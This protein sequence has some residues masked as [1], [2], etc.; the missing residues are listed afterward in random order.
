VPFQ[1]K[2]IM[3]PNKKL[4]VPKTRK[5]LVKLNKMEFRKGISGYE[6][7]I[8]Q[9]RRQKTSLKAGHISQG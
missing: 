8:S 1:E 9:I 4:R 3:A 6:A 5:Q 7:C 2:R